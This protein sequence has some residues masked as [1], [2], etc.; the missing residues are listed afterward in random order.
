MNKTALVMALKQFHRTLCHAT[1]DQ[2]TQA[3]KVLHANGEA[4]LKKMPDRLFLQIA[5][6]WEET[7][8]EAL[9]W[10]TREEREREHEALKSTGRTAAIGIRA[11]GSGME[12]KENHDRGTGAADAF[13]RYRP[14]IAREA[15]GK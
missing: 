9:E 5:K 13:N 7:I 10:L 1:D 15:R 2:K 11:A 6:G 12:H 4:F 3:C 8:G 14:I